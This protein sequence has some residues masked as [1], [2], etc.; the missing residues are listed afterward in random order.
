MQIWFNQGWGWSAI[1]TIVSL[2][3]WLSDCMS[4]I[5]F[6]WLPVVTASMQLFPHSDQDRRR[7]IWDRTECPI[8]CPFSM[9]EIFGKDKSSCKSL[10]DSFSE[11]S[12][13]ESGM[14]RKE[15]CLYYGF[16]GSKTTL[17]DSFSP[18][19]DSIATYQ[20]NPKVEWQQ[21]CCYPIPFPCLS[22]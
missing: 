8:L 16:T 13:S 14:Q 5:Q 20:S 6:P 10:A 9:L 11:E 12:P 2:S 18:A 7:G 19:P 4:I 22:A 1:K 3:L 21:L 15:V 17:I